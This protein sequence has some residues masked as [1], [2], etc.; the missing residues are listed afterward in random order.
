MASSNAATC[1]T[2]E[3]DAAAGPLYLA[4]AEALASDVRAGRLAEG[5]RLPPQRAL[6]ARLG[7]E[8][9]LS[10]EARTTP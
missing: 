9:P 4:I 3:I 5:A 8:L 1:W 2:P 7:I 10:A 6:A